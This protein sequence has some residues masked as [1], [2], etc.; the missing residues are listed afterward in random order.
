MGEAFVELCPFHYRMSSIVRVRRQF[1]FPS[2]IADGAKASGRFD[3]RKRNSDGRHND[4]WA[5]L[6]ASILHFGF[7]FM[8]LHQVGPHYSTSQVPHEKPVCTFPTFPNQD[9]NL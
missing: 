3:R 8:C 6:L 1:A 9:L 4:S 2:E 7:T 5:G